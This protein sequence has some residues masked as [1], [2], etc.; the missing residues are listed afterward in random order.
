MSNR[1]T[2]LCEAVIPGWERDESDLPV[3][4]FCDM[5]ELNIIKTQFCNLTHVCVVCVTNF[6]EAYWH[7]YESNYSSPS[8][9]S[10]L[11]GFHRAL[12]KKR[13]SSNTPVHL[14]LVFLDLM[15][16]PMT[17][18]Q[19]N[20]KIWFKMIHGDSRSPRRCWAMDFFNETSA[21]RMGLGSPTKTSRLPCGLQ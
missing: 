10:L 17:W 11:V 7:E 8:S 1:D 12:S 21:K 13:P 15:A 14:M 3:R 20:R 16:L 9:P 4:K 19:R 6:C 18:W 5:R 2:E